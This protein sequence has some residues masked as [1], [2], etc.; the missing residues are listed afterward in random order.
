L[1]GIFVSASAQ[2]YQNR[3]LAADIEIAQS[4]L[5][6]YIQQCVH[7][8]STYQVITNSDIKIEVFNTFEQIYVLLEQLQV[9]ISRFKQIFLFL[10]T[11]FGFRSVKQ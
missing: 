11:L 1:Q 9:L 4:K 10:Q 7:F 2:K 8:S 6:A 5:S 3:D